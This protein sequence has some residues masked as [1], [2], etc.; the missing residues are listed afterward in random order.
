V[1]VRNS[2]RTTAVAIAGAAVLALVATGCQSATPAATDNWDDEEIT[3]TLATFNNFG[4][5]DELLAG[6]TALHPKVTVEHTIAATSN[7]ARTNYFTK[8]GAG[9]GLADVEAV[10][11]DWFAELLQY[12]DK[13]TDLTSA[14]VEGRWLPW[15]TDAATDADGRLIAYGT[16]IGPEAICYR[17]DLFA[18]AGLP[19][20]RD[21]VAAL[22]EGDWDHYYDVGRDFVANSDTAWFDSA[23]ATYQG[24]INQVQNAYE[25]NDGTIIATDNQDVK[26]IYNG[27]LE[28]SADLSA[29]LG[30]WSPDWFTGLANG[31]FATMLCPGWMLGVISGAAPDVTT[32]DVANVFPGG[33][34]NWGGSYLTVPAQGAHTEAAKALA[35][36]LTSPESQISAFVTAGTFPSQVAAYDSA[37]LTGFVNDYFNA[38]PV[39]AIFTDRAK[40][41]DVAPFKSTHYFPINDAL[42]NALARVDIDKTDTAA[43]SWDKFVTDVEALG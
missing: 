28:A 20:D 38:A 25:E 16:D 10:E 19:S 23:G 40:A 29:H 24:Q 6:F 1:T 39:G 3:L 31:A 11:I 22:L 8:L 9:S 42:M 35:D 13:L 27:T 2:R 33:G 26:D 30:Q 41:V 15:K 7:D 5:T 21:E 14:S 12:S 43:A 4:Y 18:A 32:W 34:G 36:Y 17:S 37:D